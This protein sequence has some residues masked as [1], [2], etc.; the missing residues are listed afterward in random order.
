MLVLTRKQCESVVIGNNIVVTVNDIKK[1]QIKLGIAAP[2]DVTV[3]R[4]EVL[5][6]IKLENVLSSA[7]GVTDH[8]KE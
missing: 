8:I 5:K 4:E 3:N 6:K 7:S 2:K 1:G